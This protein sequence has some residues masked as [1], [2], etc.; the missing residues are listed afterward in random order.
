M[1]IFKIFIVILIL[2]FL[3]NKLAKQFLEQTNFEKKSR[4]DFVEKV[5]GKENLSDYLDVM[6]QQTYPLEYSPYIEFKETPRIH[7]FVSVSKIGN[8][9]NKINTSICL[10]PKGGGNEIW[11]F[12]GSTTFGFG[13]K[14]NETIT[15]HLEKILSN[16][17]RVINF[18]Q[19]YFYS[20]QER[21]FF[22][23]L[24]LMYDK[25]F[26][27]I[28]IDGFNDFIQQVNSNNNFT[29]QSIISISIA[30]SFEKKSKIKILKNWFKKRFVRL[31]LV[32]LFNEKMNRDK[33]EKFIEFDEK[34][35]KYLMK[36]IKNNFKINKSI[37]NSYNIKIINILQPIAI[38]DDSYSTSNLPEDFYKKKNQSFNNHKKLYQLINKNLQIKEYIDLNLSNLKIE[39]T[40]FVD[41][42]HYSSEFNEEIARQ[43]ALKLN[44]DN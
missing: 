18:G 4:K 25:P 5:Y 19:G 10:P 1:K 3:S 40:M 20:T 29:E 38:Y 30:K 8:R 7:S 35:I 13:V 21:I 12:G 6:E 26:A 9:C 44:F 27:A 17:K 33:K 39:E 41:L 28:F 24:L 14:N 11:I 22:Q 16:K 23:N 42:A 34:K 31:N 15:A 43:I 2:L 37:G 36:R 32:R